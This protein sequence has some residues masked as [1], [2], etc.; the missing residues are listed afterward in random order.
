MVQA[1]KVS[2]NAYEIANLVPDD[3]LGFDWE[4]DVHYGRP[5]ILGVSD[6]KSIVSASHDEAFP[7][8]RALVEK[9]PN[10]ILVGHNVLQADL[11]VAADLGW[12]I[13]PNR[14]EDTIVR[15]WLLNLHLCRSVKKSDDGEGEKRG[16]G[17]MNLWSFVSLY[18]DAENWKDC[19]GEEQCLDEKR[20]CR[21][22]DVWGYNGLDAYW[23]VVAMPKVIQASRMRGVDRLYGLH[24]DV[25]LVLAKMTRDGLRVDVPYK[26]ALQVEFANR[27]REYWDKDTGKGLLP[28]NPDSPKQILAYFKS[29]GIEL[30]DTTEETI[31][32]AAERYA[33]PELDMLA[34]QKE[35]GDGADRWFAP[36]VWD[37]KSNEWV[38]YESAG[39]I[40][41]SFSFFTSSA[42]L[43]SSNPNAQNISI[44]RPEVGAKIRRCVIAPDDCDLWEAD[45]SNAENRVYLHL[46]G[47]NVPE[48]LDIH[49]DTRD[50]IGLKDDDPF[51]LKFQKAGKSAAREAV[52]SLSH[53][54]DYAEGLSLISEQ[55]LRRPNTQKEITYGCR[56]VFRDWTFDDGGKRYIISFTGGNLAERA[57]GSRSWEHRRTALQWQEKYSAKW[58]KVRDL[59]R[60]ITKQCERDRCVRPP[61]GYVTL[62]YGAPADRIKSALAIWGSQPIAHITKLAMLNVVQDPWLSLRAQIHD[63]LL[64]YVPKSCDPKQVKRRIEE[65]MVIEMPEIPGMR[66]PIEVSKGPSWAEQRKV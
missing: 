16:R 21:H 60:R 31:A 62:S 35:L 48:D 40:H 36:R 32:D 28:F 30:E 54:F 23:P 3:Y 57:F 27:K 45:L 2:R 53:A 43:V 39:Y 14:V 13:D 12:H 19:I 18:T 34:E 58:N 17:W 29:K 5:T 9:F 49:A 65:A 46:A 41:P 8:L 10:A 1:P 11:Q 64:M 4:C 33:L 20:A 61:N 7:Y 52:K 55:D 37:Y 25:S 51:A 44:R 56:I 24:R 47:H 50:A 22:H 66:V 42:R 59:Q 26:D 38:G 15:H 6:G 63:A